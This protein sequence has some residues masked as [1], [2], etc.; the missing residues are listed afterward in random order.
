MQKSSARALN[1]KY[2]KEF[3]QGRTPRYVL[4]GNAFISNSWLNNMSKLHLGDASVCNHCEQTLSQPQGMVCIRKLSEG[5]TIRTGVRIKPWGIP[6]NSSL[7]SDSMKNYEKCFIHTGI[8]VAREDSDS[9]KYFWYHE[10]RE[11]FSDHSF[12][13]Q[14][15]S[16]HP[17][18]IV[19]KSK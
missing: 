12:Y 19:L 1:F 8:L 6:N 11:V 9:T 17:E 2:T 5:I 15:Y 13:S 4:C 14:R 3:A 18:E 16:S 7:R 10:R